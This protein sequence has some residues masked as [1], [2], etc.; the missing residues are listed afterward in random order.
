MGHD[1][2][3][4]QDV[5]FYTSTPEAPWIV[6]ESDDNKRARRSAIRYALN[7]FEDPEPMADLRCDPR[8]ISR[9]ED[10]LHYEN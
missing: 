2:R 3:A 8:F 5:F 4:K 6:I 10:E 9:I 7:Q 1:I